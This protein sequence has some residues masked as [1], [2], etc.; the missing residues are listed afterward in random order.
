MKNHHHNG[1]VKN[2]A[3]S[4]NVIHESIAVRAYELWEQSGKPENQSDA[5]WLQAEQELVTGRKK[6]TGESEPLPV[7]F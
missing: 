1:P 2:S 4:R 5:L 6:A 3:N 7:S